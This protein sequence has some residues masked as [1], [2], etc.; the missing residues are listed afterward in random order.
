VKF[1][2]TIRQEP[3]FGSQS[4]GKFSAGTRITIIALRGD[5]AEVREDN[6]SLSGFIR[7]EFL[8]PVELT[9]KK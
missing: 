2:T 3:N 6:S 5:W 8:A 7:R 9:Q 1:P 4:I